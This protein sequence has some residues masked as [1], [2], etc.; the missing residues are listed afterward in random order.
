[1]VEK[2]DPERHGFSLGTLFRTS[3]LWQTKEFFN[4]STLHGVRYIAEQGRPFAERFMWFCFTAIGA[5]AAFIII[6]SLW[7]KFQTNPTITGL[8]TDFHNQHVIFPTILIC[9]LEPYDL[10]KVKAFA[11]E[12]I[13]QFDSDYELYEEFLKS[14]TSLSYGTFDEAVKKSEDFVNDRKTDELSLRSAAFASAI[15]CSDLFSFCEFRDDLI[16]CCNSFLPKYTEHGFCYAF[17]PRFQETEDTIDLFKLQHELLET[18]R[19]WAIQ[20]NLQ[21]DANIFVHAQSEI[22]GWDFRPQLEWHTTF[23]SDILITMKQTYTTEEARQLSIGQRK[24]IFPNEVR[25]KSFPF[26]EDYTFTGCMMDCRIQKSIKLCH[27]LPPFYHSLPGSSTP[28]CKVKDLPCL[29]HYASNIT[30]V[31]DCRQCELS[32]LHTVYDVDKLTKVSDSETTQEGN[33][34]IN[35]EYL[36]WPIIRYKRE[37]LFGWVDLLVSFGGI[38]GLFLGFSLLSGVEILYYF[39]LRACCMIWKDRPVL[40]EVELEKI[41]RPPERVNLSLRIGKSNCEPVKPREIKSAPANTRRQRKHEIPL[42]TTPFKQSHISVI[43]LNE[44][45]TNEK[46]LNFRYLP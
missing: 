26:D 13:S 41:N 1:M 33:M 31:M 37:V 11:E 9:P 23:S 35:V 14:L 44:T 28:Y 30:Q 39:S 3:L 8:D 42:K 6:V 46:S 12:K 25:I 19:K 38:A 7:E 45:T 27:C 34:Y 43:H 29:S 24:C 40:E 10:D 4:N 15:S 17:N 36:T 22:S 2:I 21:R 18:D 16:E 32:C 5:V 20:L